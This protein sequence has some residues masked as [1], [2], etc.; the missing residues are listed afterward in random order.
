MRQGIDVSHWQYPPGGPSNPINYEVA[1]EQGIEFV[2]ARTTNGKTYDGAFQAHFDGAQ[3]AGL[4]AAGYHY[5]RP[6]YGIQNQMDSINEVLDGREPA[7]YALDVETSDDRSAGEVRDDVWHMLMLLEANLDCPIIVY[8]ADWYW[9]DKIRD[10][11]MLADYTNQPKPRANYWPLWVADYGYNDGTPH[12][13]DVFLP[14]GWRTGEAGDGP[15]KAQ[16]EI[17]QYTSRLVL[18]GVGGS[19]TLD[20]DLMEDRFWAL[21][22]DE[23]P[24]PP[25]LELEERVEDIELQVANIKTWGESFPV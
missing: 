8:T 12:D 4:V 20:G 9:G 22:T 16:W 1:K 6:R 10:K 21:I 11:I 3:A 24:P 7:F 25:P 5:F 14:R 18:P 17:W 23:E 13:W 2:V 19:A 15:Y